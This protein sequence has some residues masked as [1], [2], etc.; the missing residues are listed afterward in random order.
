MPI[1]IIPVAILGGALILLGGKKRRR[2]Q[3]DRPP[4]SNGGGSVNSVIYLQPAHD[5]S[6]SDESSIEPSETDSEYGPDNLLITDPECNYIL[7]QDERW[8]SEQR[9]RTIA[10]ALDGMIDADAAIEIHESMMADFAPICL[11]LGREGVGPGLKTF[12]SVNSG[13][14]NSLLMQYDSLPQLLEEDAKAFGLL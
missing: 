7:H 1:P 3:R 2:P 9:R 4:V 14:I 8:F 10:Y 12:W 13:W 6:E 11:S 5:T